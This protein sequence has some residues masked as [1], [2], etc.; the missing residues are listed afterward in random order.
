MAG[1]LVPKV[2]APTLVTQAHQAAHLGHDKME[3]LI[4]KY[5]LIHDFPAYVEWNPGNVLLAHRSM[6]PL[7]INR[8]LQEYS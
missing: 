7:D 8:N 3:E 4:G 2:L 5:F 6:L 1:L